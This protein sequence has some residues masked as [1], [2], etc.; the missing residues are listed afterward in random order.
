MKA[1]EFAGDGSGGLVLKLQAARTVLKFEC[2]KFSCFSEEKET[3]F[4][5]GDT[6]LRI[7]GIMQCVQGR[8]RKYGKFMEPIDALSRMITAK[9]LRDQHIWN[10]KKAQKWMRMILRDHMNRQ[11]TVRGKL[12]V[13]DYVHSLV[14]YQLSSTEHVRLNWNELKSGYQ[15]MSDVIKSEDN[16]L[17][18]KNLSILFS[19]SASITFVVSDG[20][21]LE[22]KE[23]N[24]VVKGMSLI[25]AMGLSMEFRFD[26]DL[27]DEYRL[28]AMYRMAEGYLGVKESQW[29]CRRLENVLVF[30]VSEHHAHTRGKTLFR[31]H[32]TSIIHEGLQT[33]KGVD[34]ET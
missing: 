11:R 23:W 26:F 4:F 16:L 32:A 8:W 13:P 28:D 6:E 3:L 14:S 9:T 21:D 17:D 12:E 10:N 1:M 25:H 19:D 5:G 31:Q 30:S 33:P 24:S 27:T 20:K 18:I 29:E 15:W 7:K 2:E 22:E 34:N